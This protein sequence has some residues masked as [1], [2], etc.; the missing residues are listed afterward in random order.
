MVSCTHHL[1]MP[2]Y[3][4]SIKYHI[5]IEYLATWNHRG[6][7]GAVDQKPD[8]KYGSVNIVSQIGPIEN[9]LQGSMELST[10]FLN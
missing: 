2:S 8:R 4:G 1:K 5:V 9:K 10:L 7:P 3:L 6:I